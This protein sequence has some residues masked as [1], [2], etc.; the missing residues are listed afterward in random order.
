[1]S[2]AQIEGILAAAES[3]LQRAQGL[4]PRGQSLG[5]K[6]IANMFFEDSTRTRCSFETATFRLGGQVL[7]LTATGSSAAKGESLLDTAL[8][9]EAMG[10][11]A[12]VVRCAISGGAKLL[13]DACKCPV[14]NAGDGRH[15]H[16]TQGLLDLATVRE[17]LG[18][19]AGKT[20]VIVGD[21][22]NS[23]VARSALHGL[24]ALGADVRLVGP[25]TLVSRAFE[26]ITPSRPGQV[27]V[28]YD[29][30]EALEGADG[31]MMLRV[32]LERAAGAAISSDYH[33]LYGLTRERFARLA[34]HAV[35]MHPG[36]MNRGVEIDDAVAD[37]PTRSRILRQVTWGVAVRMAV[38]E[39]S[40]R[41]D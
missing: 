7:N 8:N 17:S 38:L 19:V 35:V 11:A 13:A 34:P 21:I 31:V 27:R 10:V 32:Q 26:A 14:I 18:T 12:I 15:E 9:V 2:R 36:P 40:L 39:H 37:D 33:E 6:I 24:V 22:T 28:M 25:P 4:V 29:F 5:D 30:D 16:P 23:R 1:M 3:N 41:G 20:L